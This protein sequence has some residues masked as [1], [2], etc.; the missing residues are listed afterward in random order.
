MCRFIT[1]SLPISIKKYEK[2]SFWAQLAHFRP[3][4][5]PLVGGVDFEKGPKIS[6]KH[7]NVPLSQSFR[8]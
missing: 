7:H 3:L 1:I 5:D 4:W 2:W 8:F 6:R